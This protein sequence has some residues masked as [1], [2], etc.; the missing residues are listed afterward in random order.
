[1]SKNFILILEDVLLFQKP[2]IKIR[3]N[4][5]H[6]KNLK[7][8]DLAISILENYESKYIILLNLFVNLFTLY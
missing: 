1:M 2:K 8:L 5:H 6:I 7:K 4:L 3:E